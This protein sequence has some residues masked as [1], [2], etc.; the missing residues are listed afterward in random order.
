[1]SWQYLTGSFEGVLKQK[2][3]YLD[4]LNAIA[5]RFA[6]TEHPITPDTTYNDAILDSGLSTLVMGFDVDGT[7]LA[8]RGNPGTGGVNAPTFR[9]W[10]GS[11]LNYVMT[12]YYARRMTGI[13][14]AQRISKSGFSPKGAGNY[15]LINPY[16]FTDARI[17]E[18]IPSTSGFNSF[19]WINGYSSTYAR[20]LKRMIQECKHLVLPA[21]VEIL[22]VEEREGTDNSD[23]EEAVDE[24]LSATP[25]SE[26]TDD[27]NAFAAAV[28]DRPAGGM[29]AR[30]RR[31]QIRVKIP[32]VPPWNNGPVDLHF[33]MGTSVLPRS[34]YPV[35]NAGFAGYT[36]TDFYLDSALI[37]NPEQSSLFVPDSVFDS[38]PPDTIGARGFPEAI[39]GL[40]V[41]THDIWLE[42]LAWSNKTALMQYE[43]IPA[44]PDDV[45]RTMFLWPTCVGQLTRP[46]A[47]TMDFDYD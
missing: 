44:I 32:D 10:F 31:V 34:P 45:A 3:Y 35:F 2:E 26:P 5:E 43:P 46:F 23:F 20:I 25:T 8:L 36:A 1:M 16:N 18:G 7:T 13:T 40:T 41:G 24:C 29:R 38:P 37:S 27:D 42:P 17:D 30:V 15:H 33:Y 19:G 4:V 47:A 28:G 39:E 11:N 14:Q 9:S 6:A 22:A 12:D 21:D